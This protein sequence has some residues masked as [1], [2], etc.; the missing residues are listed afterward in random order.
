MSAFESI[1][2]EKI[3][4]EYE[5]LF[6]WTPEN[7]EDLQLVAGET[8]TVIEQNSHGWWL[9]I[10]TRGGGEGSPAQIRKGYF[11]KN[12]VRAKNIPPPLP[13]RPANM[14]SGQS[15]MAGSTQPTVAESNRVSKRLNTNFINAQADSKKHS[16]SLKSL[17]AFDDLMEN[18]I[19]IEIEH[20]E[21]ESSPEI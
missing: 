7:P 5:V 20:R 19:S 10:S 12:Y 2:A 18:G 13:P 15:S 1:A 16:F 14:I 9:G 17:K 6:D 3:G 8:I 4:E 11:P 21:S